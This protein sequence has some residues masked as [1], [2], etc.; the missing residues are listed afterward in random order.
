MMSDGEKEKPRL[1]VI[2]GGKATE[3]QGRDGGFQRKANKRTEKKC[4]ISSIIPE[5]EAQKLVMRCKSDPTLAPYAEMRKLLA[6]Y[7]LKMVQKHK[8]EET[9]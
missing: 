6:R 5:K 7:G 3:D 8:Q 1:K 2:E 4:C 9:P